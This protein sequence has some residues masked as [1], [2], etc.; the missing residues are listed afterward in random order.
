MRRPLL[1][2]ANSPNCGRTS[3]EEEFT[4][5]SGDGEEKFENEELLGTHTVGT[6]KKKRNLLK[7]RTKSKRIQSV[8]SLDSVLEGLADLEV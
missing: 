6:P 2:K 4:F 7:I 8:W 5:H 1:K 3:T